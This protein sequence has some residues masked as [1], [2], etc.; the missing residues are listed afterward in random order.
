[1]SEL[2]DLTLRQAS[3]LVRDRSISAV[4]LTEASI[5]RIE[6]TEPL[7]H[8]FAFFRPDRARIEAN[9]ADEELRQGRWRGP[10]HGIPMGVKDLLYTNDQPTEAGSKVLAGYR[11]TYDATVVT[12]LRQSGAI[13]VGKTVTHEFAF[14]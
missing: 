13:V 6:A 11:P 4:E 12:K 7:I 3:D 1:M 2:T 5:Q 9:T 10:L 14:G 8:A